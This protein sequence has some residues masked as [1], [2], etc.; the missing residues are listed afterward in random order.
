M[1][2]N[3]CPLPEELFSAHFFLSDQS[4]PQDTLNYTNGF[5]QKG[6]VLLA[7]VTIFNDGKFNA[8]LSKMI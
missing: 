1:Q 5:M 2:A 6:K 8:E 4:S 7:S 3:M